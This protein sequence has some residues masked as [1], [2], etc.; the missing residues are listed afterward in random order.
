[1]GTSTILT[2]NKNFLYRLQIMQNQMALTK[3]SK[4]Y[5]VS[6][7]ILNQQFFFDFIRLLTT[8]KKIGQNSNSYNQAFLQV[9]QS[10]FKS[11][12]INQQQLTLN[13]TNIAAQKKLQKSKTFKSD[14]LMLA[15][16]IFTE[17][18]KNR[19]AAISL[20]N[21]GSNNFSGSLDRNLLK[22]IEIFLRKF[23][24]NILGVK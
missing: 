7:N 8:S 1:M 19:I 10:V 24:Y 17:F 9:F 4:D 12:L 3:A 11:F 18:I 13:I 21:T 14:F 15:P 23:K 16:N 20:V 6:C 22:L 2:L 5:K